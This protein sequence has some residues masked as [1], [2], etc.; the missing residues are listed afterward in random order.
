MYVC[1]CKGVTD[2]A[3]AR[4][5]AEDG[6][7]TMRDLKVL[8]GVGSQCGRCTCQ[9]RDIMHDAIQRECQPVEITNAATAQVEVCY[10]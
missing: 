5:V 2:K 4:S 3:I 8:H 7:R 1:L 9:A 10:T 6:A